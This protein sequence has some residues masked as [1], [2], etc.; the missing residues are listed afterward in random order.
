MKRFGA[1]LMLFALLLFVPHLTAQRSFADYY[2]QYPFQ[3]DHSAIKI[4]FLLDGEIQEV[5]PGNDNK[6]HKCT[7]KSNIWTKDDKHAM[8]Y[9]YSRIPHHIIE[10]KSENVGGQ[11]ITKCTFQVNVMCPPSYYQ[12]LGRCYKVYP[13]RFS[14]ASAKKYCEDL[15][16]KKG[17]NARL[18]EYYS[19]NLRVDLSQLSLDSVWVN[20][21][22]L[23]TLYANG[24]GKTAAVYVL[25]TAFQYDLKPGTIMMD[26]ERSNH[27]AL[28]EHTPP[29]T[30]AEM[31][32]L[33]ERYNEIYPIHVTETGA[34]FATSSYMTITQEGLNET[35]QG[36]F[37]PKFN[38]Q[39]IRD[40]CMS[41]GNVINVKSYPLVSI[42]EEW[43]QERVNGLRNHRFH[44]TSAFK[45]DGCN[46]LE[47]KDWDSI[48]ETQVPVYQMKS[49]ADLHDKDHCNAHSFSFHVEAR[50]PTMAAMRAPAL[51]TLHSFSFGYAP[52]PVNAGF[53]LVE[54]DR[55]NGTK[56]CHYIE[57]DHPVRYEEAKVKCSEIKSG[58]SGFESPAEFSA[59]AKRIA[60]KTN[61]FDQHYWLG[62]DIPCKVDCRQGY[63]ASWTFGVSRNTSFLN[64]YNHLGYEWTDQ[65][66]FDTISFRKDV[67]AF[68]S[69]HHNDYAK[70]NF[71][72]GRYPEM[73]TVKNDIKTVKNTS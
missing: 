6:G 65:K 23:D 55:G 15:S 17:S 2:K 53:E 72:C 49:Q 42:E 30:M 73:V 51:C 69:H 14:Y 59:V 39:A 60:P 31:Y 61:Q 37:V 34:S 10:A 21:P 29:M 71:V 54:F 43:E 19:D 44:L 27:D 68:H 33:A 9:C 58:L 32:L 4:C 66:N 13:G 8:E 67:N 40:V 56:F 20:V 63:V 47:Y 48:T 57:N 16:V 12:I 70:M 52:C 22:H 18:A 1:H 24:K 5:V 50:L 64:N 36:A 3:L 7:I 41:I 45:N 26:D 35:N 46:H 28:C 11:L 25:D 38:T 62:G